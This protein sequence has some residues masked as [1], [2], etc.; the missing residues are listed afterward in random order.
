MRPEHKEERAPVRSFSGEGRSQCPPTPNS[1]RKTATQLWRGTAPWIVS[2]WR[3]PQT[4]PV[5]TCY[6]RARSQKCMYVTTCRIKKKSYWIRQRHPSLLVALSPS[7]HY[8]ASRSPKS[9]IICLEVLAGTQ[10]ASGLSGRTDPLSG[11]SWVL[12]VAAGTIGYKG[13]SKESTCVL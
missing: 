6:A 9:T 12:A 3:C 4:K 10:A 11:R 5:R 7:R 8:G 1:G 2:A 13:S